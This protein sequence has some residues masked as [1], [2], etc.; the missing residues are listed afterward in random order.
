MDKTKIEF[1][2]TLNKDK[3]KIPDMCV[4]NVVRIL[5][6]EFNIK[7]DNFTYNIIIDDRPFEEFDIGKIQRYL[8][9]NYFFLRKVSQSMVYEA[10]LQTAKKNE[11][12]SAK[13]YF[14]SLV[15]DKV[16]RLDTWLSSVYGT[17][18]DEYHRTVGSNFLK[19]MVK[20]VMYPG[21]KFDYVF[22]VEGEQGTR[23]STS[24]SILGAD[25]Y[26]ETTMSTETK[27]FFMQFT[28]NMIIEFSEGETMSR[29]DTKRM[30]AIVTTQVDKFRPPYEKTVKEFKRRCV[31]TMTTNND[32][33]LKDETGNRRWLP[34]SLR[35]EG[36]AD[37]DWLIENRDQLFA[38]AYHRVIT[39]K[40]TVHEFPIEETLR[41]QELR[42]E[43]HPWE[44]LVDDWY[45]NKL[46]EQERRDGVIVTYI[47]ENVIHRNLQA[48]PISRYDEMIIATIL[49]RLGLDKK[50]ISKGGARLTKWF[51]VDDSRISILPV[52]ELINGYEF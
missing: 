12:D 14:T 36:G 25:W 10:I 40:E 3:V 1:L 23:K 17:P 4:E 15:W 43:E 49:K 51:L 37:T 6:L 26:V 52:K 28:G 22:V 13:D 27:D 31:F 32:Q 42:Q 34:I 44:G 45:W 38:E 48:K 18:E 9:I 46:S 7:Y 5:L 41:Q 33:Y 19:G 8:S 47:F 50:R 29:T 20:R 16:P 35:R 30:K 39:L 24:L 11:F 21:C 2:S